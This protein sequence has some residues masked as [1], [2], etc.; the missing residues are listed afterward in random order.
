MRY[1][2]K[3]QSGTIVATFNSKK[4]YSNHL[5]ELRKSNDLDWSVGSTYVTRHPNKGTFNLFNTKTGELVEF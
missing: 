1:S 5:D 4:E 2:L 3:D